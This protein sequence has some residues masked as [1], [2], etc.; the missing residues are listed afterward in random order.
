MSSIRL[1][2]ASCVDQ[3]V[4][5]VV[6]AANKHLIAGSGLCGAIFAKA[7]SRE[8]TEACKAYKTPLQDGDAVITK[9]FGIRNAKAIIHAAGPNFAYTPDAF[10]AL[11]LAYYNSL[12][13]LK[14]NGYHSIAFPLISSG[15]YGGAL[16]NPV[17]V[18]TTQCLK[19]YHLFLK[20]HPDPVLFIAQE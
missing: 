13:V 6:N 10:N 8:L 11:C 1:I 14:E 20:T 17:D 18:S 16:E 15:I 3:N 2:H 9:S 5:A 19:A 7:G 12:I 4:D